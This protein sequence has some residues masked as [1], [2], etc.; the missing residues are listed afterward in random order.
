M[1]P[2]LISLIRTW[3][4]LAAGFVLSLPGVPWL[5]DLL[6]VSSDRATEVVSGLVSLALAALWYAV[7]RALE[8]RW[9]R[10]GVLLGVPTAPAYPKSVA[11]SPRAA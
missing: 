4:A 8:H 1:S 3:A 5:L 2:Y 6:G 11:A 7:V 10:L 9:P